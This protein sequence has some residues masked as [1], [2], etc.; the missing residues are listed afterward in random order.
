MNDSSSISWFGMTRLQLVHR[1]RE[2]ADE[3]EVPSI[4]INGPITRIDQWTVA[5]RAVP[6]LIG[7]PTSHPKITDGEPLYSS[8]L[9][10]LDPQKR[11]A[12]SFSRWY[13]LGEQVDSGQ[14]AQHLRVQP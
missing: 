6:C 2:L 11:I 1:L 13:S 3:L 7:V 10:Y 12:R 8:E 9:F 5:S 14:W 4:S